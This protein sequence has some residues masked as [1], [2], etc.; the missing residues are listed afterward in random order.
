V[1]GSA[2]TPPSA[3]VD[4]VFKIKA[5]APGSLRI[6]AELEAVV[7]VWRKAK[8]WGVYGTGWNGAP[9]PI[10]GG[11]VGGRRPRNRERRRSRQ[12]ISGGTAFWAKSPF[13]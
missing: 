6:A 1:L 12:R 10:R 7:E 5:S 9:G 13:T 3:M 11:L 8:A 4:G 2:V